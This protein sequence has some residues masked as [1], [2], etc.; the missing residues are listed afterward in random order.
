LSIKGIVLDEFSN[1]V[2]EVIV[3]LKEKNKNKKKS[4]KNSKE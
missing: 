3:F 2:E 4:K 1:K